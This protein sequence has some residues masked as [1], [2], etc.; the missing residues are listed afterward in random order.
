MFGLPYRPTDTA[1]ASAASDSKEFTV[2][3]F[4]AGK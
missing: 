1:V 3:V 4:E 2:N